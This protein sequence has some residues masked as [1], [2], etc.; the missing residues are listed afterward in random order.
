MLLTD[1]LLRIYAELGAEVSRLERDREDVRRMLRRRGVDPESTPVPRTRVTRGT[2]RR[3]GGA[4]PSRPGGYGKG[5]TA[6][7]IMSVLADGDVWRNQDVAARVGVTPTACSAAMRRLVKNGKVV[8]AGYGRYKRAPSNNGRH[9][10][11]TVTDTPGLFIPGDRDQG[12]EP[13]RP[14]TPPARSH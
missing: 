1:E 13:E 9:E 10:D 14:G 12:G 4:K 8:E 3:S 5:G 11:V 6:D 2:K 7:A